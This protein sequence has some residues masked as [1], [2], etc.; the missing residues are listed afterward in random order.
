M[1]PFIAR[2]CGSGCVRLCAMRSFISKRADV[3]IDFASAI[4]CVQ[5]SHSLPSQIVC[6]SRFWCAILHITRRWACST[7]REGIFATTLCVFLDVVYDWT[8]L[9]ERMRWESS[10]LENV[11]G[12]VTVFF[13]SFVRNV[14]INDQSYIIWE[15]KKKIVWRYFVYKKMKYSLFSSNEC[16][17]Y[18]IHIFSEQKKNLYSV[19]K[20]DTYIYFDRFIVLKFFAS[21]RILHEFELFHSYQKFA[22]STT[23]SNKSKKNLLN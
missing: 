4:Y 12:E 1:I 10:R 20:K 11:R 15:F 18:L 19:E 21:D 14:E 16:T 7:G 2:F 5:P 8:R 13:F 22:F 23:W 17:K 6:V 9:H 3:W